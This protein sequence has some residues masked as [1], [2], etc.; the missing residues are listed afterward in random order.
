[1]P[2]FLGGKINAANRAA[3]L[4]EKS[5][6]LSGESTRNALVSELVERYFGL[7][8]AMQVVDVREQ[9][10]RGVESHLRDAEALEEQG[11]I[12]RSE[13]LYVEF[14]LAEAERELAN[15]RLQVATLQDALRPIRWA[16]TARRSAR[17]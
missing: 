4:N 17:R 10:R 6:A 5:A 13:K 2:I 11:M 12:A 14:K 16:R 3:R 7:A 9:V 1:M 8:L 15:A